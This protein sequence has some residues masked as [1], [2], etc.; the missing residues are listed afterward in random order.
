MNTH[1]EHIILIAFPLQLWLHEYISMLGYTY[2]ACF[3]YIL[4]CLWTLELPCISVYLTLAKGV[5]VH[6]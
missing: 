5:L 4:F 6:T 2:Y 1:S 3:V